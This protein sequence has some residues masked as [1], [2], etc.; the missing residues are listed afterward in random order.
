MGYLVISLDFELH[1]GI[2]EKVQLEERKSYFRKTKEVIPKILRLFEANDISATWA[3]VGMLLAESKEEWE[4]YRPAMV[5]SYRHTSLSSY[6]WVAQNGYFPEFH[7]ALDLV[8]ALIQVPGQELGSHT[9]S[10]YYTR[11]EGQNIQ[12]FQADLCAAKRIAKEKVG[13]ELKSLIFP[14]NQYQQEYLKVCKEEGFTSVRTNPTD[15]FWKD[16]QSAGLVQRLF[17]TGDTLLPLG[18]RTSYPIAS[19]RPSDQLPIQI[20]ASRLL[21]PYV[22]KKP[23]LNKMRLSRVVEEM[24]AAAKSD[25]IYHLWWHP[26]NFGHHPEENL[27]DLKQVIGA[28]RT[29]QRQYGMQSLNM[30]GLAALISS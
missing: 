9:F 17:R 8:K 1:W 26:H 7:S 19:V 14:R 5:P 16:P 10:H 3:T 28:F 4:K 21:R 13:M 23:L 11:E 18:K 27:S 12:E 29:L 25:E 20:P 2:F 6:F 15:W 24:T 22:V 30:S